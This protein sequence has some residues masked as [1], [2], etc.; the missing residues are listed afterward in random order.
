AAEAAAVRTTA[1]VAAGRATRIE[2]EAAQQAAAAVQDL[3]AGLTRAISSAALAP[4]A[5]V[6]AAAPTA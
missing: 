4:M 3:A 1:D 2:A 5:N 6:M